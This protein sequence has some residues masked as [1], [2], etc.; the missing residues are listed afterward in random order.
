MSSLKSPP[1][2]VTP[3]SYIKEVLIRPVVVPMS[4][5][6]HTATGAIEQAALVLID[7]STS[8]G[9]SGRS[10]VFAFAPHIQRAVVALL[11]G[12]G[13]MI[14][15]DAVSPFEV[16]QKLRAKHLLVGM[17]NVVLFAQSGID[18]ALWDAHAQSLQQPLVQVLGGEVKKVPAY[19]SKGLG[20]MPAAEA[21][22]EAEQLLSEGFNAVKMRL[23]RGS[24]KQDLDAV[25]AVKRAIGPQATLMCD[26]NQALSVNESIR[27]G[28]MLDEEGGLYWIE[29]PTRAED[30]AGTARIAQTLDT[31]VSIGENFMG[32][33]Q[34]ADALKAGCCNY[35][36]PDVQRIG[37]VSGWMRAASLAQ[38]AGVEMSTHL[39][40]E[41]SCHLLGVTPTAHWLEFVD[42][43]A[44]VLEQ[45]AI[46]ED[47][48]LAIPDRPG[49]G[50]VWDEQAVKRYLV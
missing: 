40:P 19:N 22:A 42:W 2:S 26:F 24:A 1:I 49:A 18:M 41:F 48:M 7:I 15:G 38:V 21:A 16:E 35:V 30:Y 4:V 25:R 8:E 37:G 27:R 32:C 29:E 34:M 10:Y 36:M 11:E 20:I 39:F 6:L 44:P 31:P 46:V 45:P 3:S 14:I 33:E 43:A 5:P 12:M 13:Q 23:G 17:H 28:R 9:I 50:M 47:G